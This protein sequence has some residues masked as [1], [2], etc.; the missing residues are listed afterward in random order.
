MLTTLFYVN[1]EVPSILPCANFDTAGGIGAA[2]DGARVLP[3]RNSPVLTFFLKMGPSRP[4]YRMMDTTILLKSSSGW[5]SST[6]SVIKCKA[7]K[8]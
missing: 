8:L 6:P 7:P 5:L 1:I 3:R 2:A 4:L